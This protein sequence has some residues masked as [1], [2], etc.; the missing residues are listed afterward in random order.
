MV[1][2][3]PG[4]DDQRQ[5]IVSLTAKGRRQVEFGKREVW[6]RVE[7]A[8]ASLCKGLAGPLLDQLGQIEDGL[9]ERPL[10]RRVVDARGRKT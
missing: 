10:D 2:A 9:S 8:V 5:R 3:R 1:K 6:P 7:A 4:R